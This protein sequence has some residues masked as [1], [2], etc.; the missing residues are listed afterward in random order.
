MHIREPLLDAFGRINDGM[1]LTL[2]GLTAEQLAFRPSEQA[3]SIAWLAWHVARLQDDHIS[4]LAGRPQ[5]WVTEGWHARFDK[6][7]NAHDIGFGDSPRQVAAIRPESPRVLL[8]YFA[9]VHQRSLE[10]VRS[11]EPEHLDRVLDEP[12]WDP[13][14]TV[15]V[16]IVSVIG[17]CMQHLGQMA[18][19]RGL[20]EDRHW[21][22][23]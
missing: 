17:D 6:P 18:Y 14:V 1:R 22:P 23:A 13:P 21:F 4:N 8:D 19:I 11:L 16:R 12:Q 3:N 20:L 2:D 7:A 5:A 9:V 15:G 10:Y